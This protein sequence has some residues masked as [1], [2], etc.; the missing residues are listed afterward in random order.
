[1]GE[2]YAVPEQT[3][4]TGTSSVSG[5]ILQEM[6]VSISSSGDTHHNGTVS[7]G[8]FQRIYKKKGKKFAFYQ[9]SILFNDRN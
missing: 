9:L 8:D 4:Q 5:G 1:M 2:I 6:R 7:K 3:V